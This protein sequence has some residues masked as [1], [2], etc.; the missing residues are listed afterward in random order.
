VR[1]HA[2][3]V[4]TIVGLGVNTPGEIV[5]SR[6]AAIEADGFIFLHH[7]IGRGAIRHLCF[8]VQRSQ[9]IVALLRINAEPRRLDELRTIVAELQF[10]DIAVVIANIKVSG[11]LL[12]LN[13]CV[14]VT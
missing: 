4:P 5:A 13:R 9:L 14:A 12:Q 8:A 7:D 6:I 10:E 3:V 1:L 2:L 11:S